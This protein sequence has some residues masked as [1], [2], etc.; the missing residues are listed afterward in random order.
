MRRA[1]LAAAVAFGLLCLPPAPL[2][3][4]APPQLDDARIEEFLRTARV[5][6]VRSA[7]KG[8]TGSSRATMRLGE[9]V[10]DVHVQTVDVSQREFR[11]AQGI[12]FNFRDKWQFNVAAY[13]IDRLLGLRLVPVTVERKW[14]YDPASFTWWVDEVLA[15][16]GERV[17][18]K[19]TA[20]NE[21]CWNQ[22]RQLVRIFDQLIDNIDRNPGNLLIT[23]AW[24]VFA[25]DHTRAFRRSKTPTKP[26]NLTRMDRRVLERLAALDF[27]T[28]KREVGRYIEDADIRVLLSRRDA[29][30]A[31]FKAAGET[32]LFDRRQPATGCLAPASVN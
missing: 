24:Q 2:A 21:E 11:S 30:V 25:I 13:K 12:E 22:Q 29:I 19:L 4:Q 5:V 9:L 20:P 28:L 3:Q 18:K 14:R 6:G 26:E 31:H 17:K 10:H 27:A 8:I 32:A 15:D 16:E 23:K 1:E 7:G